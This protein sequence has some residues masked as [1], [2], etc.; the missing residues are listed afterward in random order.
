MLRRSRDK[1]DVT[2]KSTSTNYHCLQAEASQQERVSKGGSFE[3]LSR[4]S[5]SSS[6]YQSEEMRK[7][8]SYLAKIQ[9]DHKRSVE[10][11]RSIA[12]VIERKL[13]FH[14]QQRMALEDARMTRLREQLSGAKV[15]VT[16]KEEF[17]EVLAPLSE[18]QEA[19]VSQ[20]RSAL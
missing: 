5:D 10:D 7:M 17:V 9:S 14:Q 11:K 2:A 3:T 20:V 15:S 4:D 1:H 19:K 6:S 16:T 8:S 13:Q 18:A 12:E